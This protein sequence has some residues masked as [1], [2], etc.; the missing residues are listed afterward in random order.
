MAQQ[1][2]YEWE[3]GMNPETGQPYR[4]FSDRP[5][6][7]QGP[8]R[9]HDPN[10]PPLNEVYKEFGRGGQT[11][12]SQPPQQNGQPG[13]QQQPRQQQP[14]P[15]STNPYD[16]AVKNLGRD[17]RDYNVD[18]EAQQEFG[19]AAPGLSAHLFGA[20]LGENQMDEGQLAHY[21]KAR[22]QLYSNLKKKHTGILNNAQKV[23]MAEAREIEEDQ[24][25]QA[26]KRKE[27]IG[28]I[29]KQ[30]PSTSGLAK[31]FPD[32]AKRRNLAPIIKAEKTA[33]KKK[34][35]EK[36]SES[37]YRSSISN[38]KKAH[39]QTGPFGSSVAAGEAAKV[40]SRAE[41][42][43]YNQKR[44]QKNDDG[45]P[46]Y[47]PSELVT[48]SQNWVLRNEKLYW[49][50]TE[51]LKNADGVVPP[52]ALNRWNDRFQKEYGFVPVKQEDYLD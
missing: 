17:P 52:E 25:K 47:S 8:S 7:G 44:K 37:D 14:Q 30:N 28:I 49:A 51:K 39:Q 33:D 12:P 4:G 21:R 10:N 29:Q 48:V 2:Y 34:A 41:V 35:G 5:S 50:A 27:D 13:V 36:Y 9:Q 40:R 20:D 24:K 23:V 16:M 42:Q 6:Q 11:Q 3:Q 32:L 31:A 22:G 43:I 46:K 26:K 38:M 19:Q 1:G 15:T 45:S 18:F